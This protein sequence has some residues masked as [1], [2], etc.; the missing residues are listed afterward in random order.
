MNLENPFR[1]LVFGDLMK[2]LLPDLV[3]GFAFFT[4][5]A[6]AVLSKR[7]QHQRAAVAMSAAIGLAL[8]VGLVWWEQKAGLSIRNLGPLAVGFAIIILAAVM[9]Q[10]I[11][12]VGGTWAGIGI[13]LGAS[14]LISQVLNLKWPFGQE[15]IQT[16]TIV[17]L[18]TGILAFLAHHSGRAIASGPRVT[19][20][21][22]IRKDRTAAQEGHIVSDLLGRRMRNVERQVDHLH[23]HPE[24]AGDAMLQIR[25]MLPAEGWLTQRLARLR[26]NAYHAREG[27]VARIEAIQHII[28]NLPPAAKRKAGEELAAT[29]KELGLD[30]RL[31]RLDKAVAAN[32]ERVRRLTKEAQGYLAANDY[33]SLHGSLE[34]AT[35]LQK[36]N[37]HLFKLIDRAEARLAAAARQVARKHTGVTGG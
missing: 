29:Y 8:S 36:H 23:Q 32:E 28:K 16:I 20:I 15:F 33:R 1:D 26:E 22:A 34:A 21:P 11:H 25:R 27:H 24:D 31:D 7:F 35:K 18:V 9:Y 30:L 5:L 6:Y 37:S 12:H 10:A 17:A 4:A 2:S 13:A 3:L 19:E 14:L